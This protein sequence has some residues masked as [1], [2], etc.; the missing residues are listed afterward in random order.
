MTT[1]TADAVVVGVGNHI[2]GDDAVGL[3]V[4]DALAATDRLPDDTV[5]LTK[6]GVDEFQLLAAVRGHETAMIVDAM[7]G[8]PPGDVCCLSVPALKRRE[9]GHSL[10]DLSLSH[11]LEMGPELFETTY[12]ASVRVVGVGIETTAAGIGLSA[13]VEPAVTE[14]VD[15][16]CQ[17]LSETADPATP[18]QHTH[19]PVAGGDR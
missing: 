1:A 10:H 8:V 13:A 18:E 6:T 3:R 15:T 16:V 11:V 19:T 4:I 7:G 2:K 9:M 12:P 17:V 5:R 14:A